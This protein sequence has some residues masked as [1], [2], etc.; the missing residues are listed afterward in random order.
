MKALRIAV[1]VA[2]V[3][4]DVFFYGFALPVVFVATFAMVASGFSIKTI[5]RDAVETVSESQM[6]GKPSDGNVIVNRCRDTSD[7]V[8][9][10]VLTCEKQA[11][12]VTIDEQANLIA[13]H[14]FR[15]F[16]LLA[17]LGLLMRFAVGTH[18]IFGQYARAKAYL[19]KGTYR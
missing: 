15:L 10:D 17:G 18:G 13:D 6:L 4:M 2:N 7:D 19:T 5:V 8:I 11:V 12:E 14:L 1:I 16:V 9:L 3:C